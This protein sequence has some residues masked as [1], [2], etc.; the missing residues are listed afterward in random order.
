MPI[1]KP[2]LI[3]GNTVSNL[4]PSPCD[5]L[6][7]WKDAA[8]EWRR[9]HGQEE[10]LDGTKSPTW[11]QRFVHRCKSSATCAPLIQSWPYSRIR[12]KSAWLSPALLPAPLHNHE[13]TSSLCNW[14]PLLLYKAGNN[15]SVFRGLDKLTN[16]K[17][18]HRH[19]VC[20]LWKCFKGASMPTVWIYFSG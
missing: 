6:T 13:Q 2:G 16:I 8:V 3:R 1:Q 14:V 15:G 11:L 17:V 20:Y 9:A 10:G 5:L 12:V 4:G 19:Y 18:Y 7:A